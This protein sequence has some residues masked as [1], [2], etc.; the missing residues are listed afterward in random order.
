MS[1][2][3]FLVHARAG[4]AASGL[5]PPERWLQAF[6]D[7]Q[8]SN[9]ATLEA[10]LSAGDTVWVPV[11]YPEWEARVSALLARQ[12]GCGVVVVSGVLQDAEGL[13]A[14]NAGARGYCHLLAVPE[15]LREVAQVLDHGG[16]WV[17][18]SLVQRLM[19]ATREVLQRRPAAAPPPADLSALSEREAQVARAV[20]AGKSNREVAEQLFISERTVKAHLGAVFDKLGVRDRV[21]LVLH[22][23][24]SQASA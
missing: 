13:R 9:W 7:G 11:T 22:L 23:S 8:W 17:G 15:V 2:Q 20:A 12:P 19:A 1:K 5:T 6:P 10:S 4:A 18:P 3:H 16:L 21:Q 14:L 24:G